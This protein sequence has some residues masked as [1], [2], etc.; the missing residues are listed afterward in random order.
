MN[1]QQYR[2][3]ISMEKRTSI[4]TK[5]YITGIA[6]FCTLC[7]IFVVVYKA[8]IRDK[9]R[10]AVECTLMSEHKE[11]AAVYLSDDMPVFSETFLCQ[12]PELRVISV[13]CEGSEL[14]KN[15]TLI[16]RLSDADTGEEYYYKKKAVSKIAGK[17]VK[18][19]HMKLDK[20]QRD[21]EGKLLILSWELVDGDGT[22]LALTSNQKQGL[23]TGVNG[24][25]QDKTNIIYRMKYSDCSELKLLYGILCVALL[26]FYMLCYSLLVIKRQPVEKAY[27]P[28]ALM[29]GLVFNFVIMVHGVPDEPWHI[30][31]AY[32]YS[33]RIMLIKDTGNA[34]TIYK[35][36][37]DV[38]MEDMLAN[39]IESNSYY[40]LLH[41]TMEIPQNP[42]LVEVSYVDTGHIVPDIV[43][44]PAAIGIS[45]GRWL[46]LS[47][48]LT[49]SLG[50]IMNLIVF[51]LLAWC[52][53]RMI[54][55]GRNVMGMVTLLPISM[56]QAA[57]ASYDAVVHGMIFLFIAV[58]FRFAER[59]RLRIWDYLLLVVLTSFIV[60]AKSA[61]YIPLCLLLW[62][63]HNKRGDQKILTKKTLLIAGAG[64]L[65]IAA[66]MIKYLPTIM[67]LLGNAATGADSTEETYSL[68]FL[69]KHP[70]NVVYLYW[71][72]WMES[73]DNHIRGL[74]GGRLAWL[75]I[76]INWSFLI[77]LMI[78]LLL[79]ANV[80]QDRYTGNRRNRMLL[81][82]ASV[83]TIVLIMLS[84]LLGFT[85][86]DA[87]HIQGLQGRYY[88]VVLPLLLFLTCNQMVHVN[89]KQC[90]KI[91][92]TMLFTECMIVLQVVTLI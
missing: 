22:V 8:Q 68:G 35:R 6:L 78:G 88:L 21:S 86:A 2:K 73:G 62:M 51:V 77:I 58:C 54:P 31:T 26:L 79:L 65:L 17:T 85:E 42:E 13:E 60:M 81:A 67:V 20:V 52:A 9:L 89:R 34:N 32:K 37:C 57:S 40:Q 49:I 72:T 38:Q 10:N 11:N 25:Q 5:Q 91:W 69:L 53:V 47:S 74:F 75:D 39:G 48:L 15:A 76:K 63:L 7:I 27:L 44:I 43:Y 3:G 87:A 84:M 59:E 66:V 56:Q 1:E 50:R 23:V 19:I 24:I 90:E 33:D 29:L 61:V 71:N 80:E 18:L 4:Q 45:I 83:G 46:G 16:M 55:F 12:V 36:L 14:G 92:M 82:V 41:H 70:L 28:I 64:I 30:D